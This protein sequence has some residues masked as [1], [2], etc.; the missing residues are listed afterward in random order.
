MLLYSGEW[1]AVQVMTLLDEIADDYA[2]RS[3]SQVNVDETPKTHEFNVR[4]SDA[5][6]VQERP[7]EEEDRAV[8]KEDVARS[9]TASWRGYWATGRNRPTIAAAVGGP[10]GIARPRQDELRR[11]IPG[12]RRLDVIS[13]PSSRRA[14]VD[15]PDRAHAQAIPEMSRSRSRWGSRT[16]PARA[17]RTRSS[18][19]QAHARNAR[20]LRRWRARDPQEARF[21][22]G[23]GLFSPVPTTSTSARRRPAL[24]LRPATRSRYD[25]AKDGERYF[26][27]LR[28]P[29]P[30]DS[31][32]MRGA[33]SSC[34][35]PD[36]D[37]SDQGYQD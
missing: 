26:A 16:L 2:G 25:P 5:D 22:A 37:A 23:R 8:R 20:T 15:E 3:R 4:G 6:P 9:G 32:T 34:R 10:D 1:A 13:R 11:T 24:N 17:S 30:F 35:E 31:T 29:E 28:R 18:P 27:L 7:A 19:P 36:A 12:R 21:C 14:A 33:R